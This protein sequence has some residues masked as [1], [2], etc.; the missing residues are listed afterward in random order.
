MEDEPNWE[1]YHA[2]ELVNGKPKDPYEC[3]RCGSFDFCLEGHILKC[4]QCDLTIQ[5]IVTPVKKE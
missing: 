5:F 1:S 3:P 2:Y 4:R